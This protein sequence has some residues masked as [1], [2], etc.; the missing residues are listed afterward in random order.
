[1]FIGFIGLFIKSFG[2]PG[3]YYL[4]LPS[5][6]RP[7][8]NIKGKANYDKRPKKKLPVL[9]TGKTDKSTLFSYN[10]LSN[11]GSLNKFTNPLYPS[12]FK[13]SAYLPSPSTLTL[14]IT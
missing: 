13:N 7:P 14:S 3:P 8:K 5:N 4:M 9:S 11:Y 1:M 12:I 2:P 10:I 6:A